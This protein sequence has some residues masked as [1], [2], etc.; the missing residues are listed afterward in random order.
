MFTGPGARLKQAGSAGRSSLFAN[1]FDQIESFFRAISTKY[2]D[3][4]TAAKGAF[5][6]VPLVPLKS[7][8]LYAVTDN[9]RVGDAFFALADDGVQW[10]RGAV[11]A[12]SATGISVWVSDNNFTARGSSSWRIACWPS[13]RGAWTES[14]NLNILSFL[15]ILLYGLSNTIPTRAFNSLLFSFAD[16]SFTVATR[17]LVIRPNADANAANY[18]GGRIDYDSAT[19]PALNNVANF[20][21]TVT[22]A[23]AATVSGWVRIEGI[24]NE[25]GPI[26]YTGFLRNSTPV[27]ASVSGLYFGTVPLTTLDVTINGSGDFDGAGT[28]SVQFY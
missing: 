25:R 6:G 28:Y 17:A 15:S 12:I 9:F 14:G 23:A 24:G 21:P 18:R 27:T 8:A 2:F 1:R 3:I 26:A 4:T 7:T 19:A 5:I 22:Q 20:L 16:V 11:S 10:I 13:A